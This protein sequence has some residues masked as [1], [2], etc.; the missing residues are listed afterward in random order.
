MHISIKKW[1]MLPVVVM[2]VT[3]L[4]LA[5][6]SAETGSGG[7]SDSIK[8]I[9][10]NTV[11]PLSSVWAEDF[12]KAN[13]KVSIA[14]SGPG[15]G[16]GI[17]AL[18]D[19]MTD[20]CQSSR[21]IKQSEIDQAKAKGVNPYE[22]QVASDGLSVVLHPSNPVSELT[23]AQLSAIYTNQ[24]TN[25]KEVGGNDAPIVVLS[26]D[27][28]SGTHV[29][30]KEHVVQMA[31]LPTQNTKLEYGSNVLFLPSTEQGV[32]EV[33]RNSNAIFYPGLGYVTSQV[34]LVKIKKTASDPSILSSEKTVLD[35]TYLIARPLLFYTNGVP[36]GIIKAFIDYCLSP[37]GQN[38][39]T[40]VGYVPLAK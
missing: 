29:F 20:I 17:A 12:M 13:P 33:A 34:K 5:G 11:T 2:L 35:G 27:T 4:V 14:V 1:F 32:S 28:N 26:R 7:L 6:C 38:K 8:I 40:E 18:I 21:T 39:V 22:I 36:T 24:I 9:G 25:W 10:S 37:E 30:F 31:G 16:A 19:G 15:S 23:I 3:A